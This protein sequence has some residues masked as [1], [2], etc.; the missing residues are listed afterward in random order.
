MGL[1]SRQAYMPLKKQVHNGIQQTR[2]D[3]NLLCI[4]AYMQHKDFDFP[5]FIQDRLLFK[6]G[7]Y[8]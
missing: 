3:C 1:Y 6:V 4:E 7:F 2:N 8:T 5:A